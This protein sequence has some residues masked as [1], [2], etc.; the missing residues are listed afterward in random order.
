VE[1][2]ARLKREREREREKKG[3]LGSGK[4]TMVASKWR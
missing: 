2:M 4:P 3:E 1:L